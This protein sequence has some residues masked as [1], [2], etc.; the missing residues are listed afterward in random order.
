MNIDDPIDLGWTKLSL[1]DSNWKHGFSC[2]IDY[3]PNSSSTADAIG[4][5]FDIYETKDGEFLLK[6]KIIGQRGFMAPGHIAAEGFFPIPRDIAI[7]LINRNSNPV[8]TNN[9][10]TPLNVLV[11]AFY[12]WI[13]E[14]VPAIANLPT[15]KDFENDLREMLTCFNSSSYRGCLAMAGVVLERTLRH[16]LDSMGIEIQNDWMVGRLL[17]EISDAGEYVDPSL[18]NIWNI[19]NQ[20]R[21]VGVHTKENIP[22]PSADQAAMVLYAVKDTIT[23]VITAQQVAPPDGRCARK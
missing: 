3:A 11:G 7:L 23:R 1:S 17:G 9:T 15:G 4:D 5:H 18:K 19:I 6:F 14:V 21:I 16:K 10:T 22:I 12:D 2:L 8:V 13:D 20:Q